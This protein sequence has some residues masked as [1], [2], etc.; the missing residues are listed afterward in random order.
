M[1]DLDRTTLDRILP[2]TTG[3]PDWD[4][5]L[6]RSGAYLARRRRLVVA[7]AAA[8]LVAV[9]TASAF[10]NVRDF[11]RGVGFI[12]LPPKGAP[13]SAPER[14]GAT[15]N[16]PKTGKLVL[17][18]WGPAAGN[19]DYGLYGV[20]KSRI[21]VYADG[22]LIF[23]RE[24]AI[25]EGAN[26]LFT[27]FLEQRLTPKGVELLRSEIVSTGLLGNDQG[28]RG[29]EPVPLGTDIQVRD[30]DR[31]VRVDR[32]SNLDR[33]VARLTNPAS[34]LPAS[35]WKDR[36]IRAYVPSR[37]K[38]LYGALPQT[39]EPS[40]ILALLPAPVEDMLRA[41]RT[42]RTQGSVGTPG[43]MHVVYSY[44]SDLT[45]EEARAAAEALDNAGLERFEPTKVLAY[46]IEAPGRSGN[47]I[48]I[49][50]E[51]YL[52]HGETTCSPCG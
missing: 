42:T 30:G 27:G 20:G 15:P 12:G 23:L 5:V 45:I 14:G 18:Y 34:W 24:A 8:A 38:V 29:T 17:F 25:P 21:W 10:G 39:M 2:S 48:V 3:S 40:R 13:P 9:G 37:F 11:V 41:K 16:A 32:A 43:Q 46:R 22:R 19:S 51:P 47:T 52:P 31:L 33:L 49:S 44:S 35:A 7:I 26:R 50:F 1:S 36:K 28:P 4:D 6:N